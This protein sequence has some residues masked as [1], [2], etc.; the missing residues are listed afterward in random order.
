MGPEALPHP[1]IP[2]VLS[3]HRPWMLVVS[4]R[5][6]RVY[7][8]TVPLRGLLACTI[9]SLVVINKE[10]AIISL[11]SHRSASHLVSW[12]ICFP[13]L[14]SLKWRAAGGIGGHQELC[15]QKRSVG[16]TELGSPAFWRGALW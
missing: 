12:A 13:S 4:G 3:T 7:S 11:V 15:H 16:G 14:S 10:P 2:P 8:E 6:P 1:T 9:H 5:I